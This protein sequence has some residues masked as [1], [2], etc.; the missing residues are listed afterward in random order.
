MRDTIYALLDGPYVSLG[1]TKEMLKGI[2]TLTLIMPGHN[3]VHPRG[4]AEQLH[5]LI[6][7]F[8]WAEVAPHSEAPKKY[9]QVVPQFLAAVEG[10]SL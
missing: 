6:P 5:R 4:V 8:H 3:D 1:M 10:N 9:V 2:Q 7:G